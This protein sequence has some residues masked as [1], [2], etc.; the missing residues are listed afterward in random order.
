MQKY[1]RVEDIPK[2]SSPYHDYGVRQYTAAE[3]AK[4]YWMGLTVLYPRKWGKTTDDMYK[5]LV[6]LAESEVRLK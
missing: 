5:L 3:I 1:I 6:K 4:E 2:V